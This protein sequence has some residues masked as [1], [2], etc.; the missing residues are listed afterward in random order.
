MVVVAVS[1]GGGVGG[2]GIGGI[3]CLYHVAVDID[4]HSFGAVRT[5]KIAQTVTPAGVGKVDAKRA[6]GVRSV[7]S[8]MSHPA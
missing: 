2:G 5:G 1:V 8:R 3:V 7:R 4:K 6:R